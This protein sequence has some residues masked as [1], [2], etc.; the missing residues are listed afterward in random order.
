MQAVE[1][2]GHG[3]CPT[4][5]IS[6]EF[7]FD[8][9][10]QRSSLESTLPITIKF[11]SR[12]DSVTRD[13]CKILLWLVEYI[14]ILEHP[15]F[16]I[17]FRIRSKYHPTNDILI[18]FKIRPKFA[19]LWFKMSQLSGN[20]RNAKFWNLIMLLPAYNTIYSS[21]KLLYTSRSW[22]PALSILVKPNGN[23]SKTC[24]SEWR[25]FAL[26]SLSDW[27]NVPSTVVT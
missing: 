13:V 22:R 19:V 5:D 2:G 20:L 6:I 14:L 15:K 3:A 10:L 23:V 26:P 9:I 17:E 7:K 27:F 21:V 11:C 18:K 1:D 25:C 8:Q 12:H 4:N 16:L 24:K